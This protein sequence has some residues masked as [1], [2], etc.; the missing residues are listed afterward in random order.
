MRN[1]IKMRSEICRVPFQPPPFSLSPSISP[2]PAPTCH[3]L[4]PSIPGLSPASLSPNPRNPAALCVSHNTLR[5]NAHI[6]LFGK[7]SHYCSVHKQ[8]LFLASPPP[9]ISHGLISTEHA[10]A[11]FYLCS[12]YKD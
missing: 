7:C 9:P 5:E 12:P 8:G 3:G 4:E 2:G 10:Q 6:S 1:H 11:A